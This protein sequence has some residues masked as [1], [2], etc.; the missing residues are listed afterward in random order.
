MANRTVKCYCPKCKQITTHYILG[1]G[2]NCSDEPD[3]FWWREEY[4]VVM[5]CGCNTVS[6]N[7][8]SVDESMEDYDPVDGTTIHV[9]VQ[10]N[11]PV[12]QK[13]ISLIGRYQIPNKVYALY[14]E[15][16]SAINNRLFLL[17]SAGFRA[18]IEGICLD[19]GINSS[20]AS[21][22]EAKINKLKTEGFITKNDRDRLH[23]V[24]F[25]GNDSVHQLAAPSEAQIRVVYE[26][27]I[28]L[29]KNLY[30]IDSQTEG[31]LESPIKSVD[32][33]IPLLDSNLSTFTIGQTLTLKQAL[34]HDKRILKDD[35]PQLESALIEKINN[36]EYTK[37]SI[38]SPA[39]SGSATRYT[40]LSIS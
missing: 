12:D 3:D 30:V 2:T 27:V 32:E 26:I 20:R 21:N 19:K 7:L 39:S 9:P 10:R 24:R 6:F 38:A 29:I 17:A 35:L 33:L 15:T 37:L 11:F 40:I 5:C 25:L 36:G 23:S 1:D 13:D 8:E 31:F 18:I 22:L 4:R 28:A 16:V 34:P 14:S